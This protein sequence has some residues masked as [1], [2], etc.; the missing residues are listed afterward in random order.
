MTMSPSRGTRKST[1]RKSSSAERQSVDP[2]HASPIDRPLDK[3]LSYR[4]ARL[5]HLIGRTTA[6]FYADEN[7][8]SHQWKVMS[9]LYHYAPMSASDVRPWVSF[10]K[11]AI[12][13]AVKQLLE[14]GLV[15]RRL[16]E[17]D[18][19]AIYIELTPKGRRISE[20]M[21]SRVL[22]AQDE[23][24]ASVATKEKEALFPLLDQLDAGLQALIA[25]RS[26]AEAGKK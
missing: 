21:T 17:R 9:V 25:Q 23:L 14:A 18:G 26:G 15:V 11:S 7:L 10:D 4:I 16:H 12:S 22:N 5:H 24:L 19:R 20:R 8:S 13:Q 1:N 2:A 3:I 6:S